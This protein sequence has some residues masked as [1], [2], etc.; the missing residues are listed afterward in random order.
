VINTPHLAGVDEAEC[1]RNGQWMV[2]ELERYLNGEP[3]RFAVTREQ[4]AIMA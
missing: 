4:A 3:L 2:A 1:K